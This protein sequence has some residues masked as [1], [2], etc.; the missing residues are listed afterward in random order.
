MA[1]QWQ[2]GPDRD[3]L[4]MQQVVPDLAVVQ[5]GGRGVQAVHHP[6]DRIDPVMCLHTEIPVVALLCT[7]HLGVPRP[8][9]VL[10]GGRRV[11]DRRID[12]SPGPQADPLVRQM[13]VHIRKDR[14]AQPVPLQQVA[15]ILCTDRFL[16]TSL[17]NS[18]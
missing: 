9:L 10:R 8:G 17:G 15:L 6:A 14:L 18:Y 12:Q 1:R 16:K 3:L 4:T 5:F 11:D 7:A 13:R 2:L